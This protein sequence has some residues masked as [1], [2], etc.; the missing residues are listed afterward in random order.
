[1]SYDHAI[2]LQPGQQSK[3]LSLKKIKIIFKNE[4]DSSSDNIRKTGQPWWLMPV[5]LALC[6]AET[7]ESPEVRNSRP[8]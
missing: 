7:G 8:T 5:K 2:A 1:M 6:E 4:K 3:T